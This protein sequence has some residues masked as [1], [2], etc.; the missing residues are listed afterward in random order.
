MLIDLPP[1]LLTIGAS[2]VPLKSP[3]NCTIPLAIVV[4]SPALLLI[5]LLST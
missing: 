1:I 3:A 4:A 2:A 5:I